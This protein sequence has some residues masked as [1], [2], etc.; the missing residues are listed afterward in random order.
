MN[1]LGE[2][3]LGGQVELNRALADAAAF[4]QGRARRHQQ[5]QAREAVHQLRARADDALTRLRGL[6][7]T[8]RD[9]VAAGLRPALTPFSP[10]PPSL[11]QPP[12]ITPC[13]CRR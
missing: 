6:A 12:N 2:G 5:V 4:S 3:A 8:R 13:Y 11:S 1:R 7:P 10:R 9:V